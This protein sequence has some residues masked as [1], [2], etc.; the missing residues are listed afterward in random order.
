[1]ELPRIEYLYG[2]MVEVLIAPVTSRILQTALECRVFDCLDR[3]I[4]APAV[5]KRLGFDPLSGFGFPREEARGVCLRRLRYPKGY[6]EGD[7]L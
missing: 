3:A 1:M 7:S 6:K 4:A 2:D 5:A